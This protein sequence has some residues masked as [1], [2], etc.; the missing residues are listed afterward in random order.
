VREQID[1]FDVGVEDKHYDY[2]KY[3][4]NHDKTIKLFEAFAGIGCQAMAFKRLGLKY[5]SVGISEIDKYA[6]K[7]YNAIHGKTKNY[8]DICKMDSIPECDIF[9]WSFP[10]FTADTLVLTENGNK[11]ISDLSVGETVLTHENRYMK[12]LKTMNNGEKEIYRIKAMSVDEIRTTKNHRFFVRE[13]Y[14]LWNNDRRSYDRLFHPPK[15]VETKDLTKNHYLGIAINTKSELPEYTGFLKEYVDG[16]KYHKNRLFL[17]MVKSDFWWI[18][19][20]YIGD[21]W[22]RTQQGI[23]ICDDKRTYHEITDVLDRLEWN[24]NVIFEKTVAK[25][26][27]PFAEIKE[28]T[29]QFGKGASGKH[30][31]KDVLNLPIDLLKSFLDGY[32]SAD[33][34]IINELTKA[35]SVSKQLIYDVAQCVAKVY[36]TPYRIYSYNRGDCVIEGRSVHQKKGYMLVF[37]KKRNKQDKAFYEDGYIWFPI[38]EIKIDGIETVY[39]IEVE[40]DHSF[41]ANGT[42]AHNCTDLSKAGKQKGMIKRKEKQEIDKSVFT[43]KYSY[44]FFDGMATA[45]SQEQLY[46]Q[47]AEYQNEEKPFYIIEGESIG[48]GLGS[49]ETEKILPKQMRPEVIK[50]LQNRLFDLEQQEG[51]RSG[52]VYEVL[53]L[54]HNTV[55]KPKVLIM[56]NVVDLVQVK[57]MA[58]FYEIQKEIESLGYKN[59]TTTL[60]AK[61]HGVAQNRDRVFMVS[62]LGGGRYEFPPRQRLE[63]RLKDYLEDNVDEK[64]YLSEKAIKGIQN[65]SFNTTKNRIQADDEPCDTLCAGDYKGPKCVQDRIYDTNGTSTAITT[66]FMPSIAIPEATKKGYSL[67]SDGD[68]VY[69]NRPHQKRGV[70]KG[71]IQ[72]LKTSGEDVGVVVNPLKGISN[73]G[74][75]F[76]Q[77][78]YDEKGIVRTIKASEGSGNMPKVL[79]NLRIRKL[80]PKECW[81]LMGISDEDFDKA[82]KVVSN[83]QLYKQAGNGIVVDVFVEILRGLF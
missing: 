47:I 72:T 18:I 35:S 70:Q 69:L 46:E 75:H 30:L 63:K 3:F 11:K 80:T 24:Y 57:F 10:C 19:G 40:S 82:S 59:Y 44:D 1:I 83:S 5:E 79:N 8:G 51:T 56:E 6:I 65:S 78:I 23:I 41:M 22:A 16:R 7:S 66:S 48:L 71:I 13:K 37:K 81:R 9:T 26:H 54:L 42:I 68:G 33:G 36:K 14:K 49:F 64:Y 31:S 52:L 28:Y 55:Q 27:I 62:L 20:R 34:S 32:F 60:N 38:N 76:E 53:R 58:E 39:D 4:E 29:K 50:I 61:Y 43:E 25:V 2:K 12:I 73:Y 15:W 21:G 77:Q 67:A 45:L 17:D 74:W